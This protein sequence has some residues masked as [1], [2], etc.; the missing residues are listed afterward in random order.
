MLVDAREL[1]MS[2]MILGQS[3]CAAQGAEGLQAAVRRDVR[4]LGRLRHRNVEDL[5]AIAQAV[6]HMRAGSLRTWRRSIW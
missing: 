6:S 3:Q 2:E 1:T 4:E 5:L